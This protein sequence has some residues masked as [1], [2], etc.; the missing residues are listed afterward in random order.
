MGIVL[1]FYKP[2]ASFQFVSSPWLYRQRLVEVVIVS[3]LLVGILDLRLYR[4][5]GGK[6]P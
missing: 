2:V 1:A 4:I 6:G 5:G 3:Y